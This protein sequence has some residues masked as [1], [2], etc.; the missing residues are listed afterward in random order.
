MDTLLPSAHRQKI[1][2]QIQPLLPQ[3]PIEPLRIKLDEQIYIVKF[4]RRE[5]GRLWRE[6][7][8][9]LA[10]W[11]L[12]RVAVRPNAFRTGDI[13]YEAQRLR[14]LHALQLP[15]P[16]LLMEGP[17]YIVM[18]YC[19][20]PVEPKLRTAEGRA[21]F[22]PRI[23]DSLLQLHEKDQWHG[24]AQARNLTIQNDQIY[25]ID[26][27]E[28]T[29]DVLPLALAQVFDLFLCFNSI[30]KYLDFD[31][32]Q[33]E[34]LLTR[35]LQGRREPAIHDKL[36]KVLRV[37]LRLRKVFDLLGSRFKSH[38]DIRRTLYFT[39][40]LERSLERSKIDIGIKP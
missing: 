5:S 24:G 2:E 22:F 17:N 14:D 25:R 9:T 37:A 29:G 11:L 7:M 3:P 16:Q 38:S 23:I 4:T 1:E 13:R 33:G 18:Q 28:K 26:F 34:R 10:C 39:A 31:V 35:Y 27:E 15:V 6:S 30:T 8:S 19:G 40:V 12:F 36:Q 21:E 20:E 32:E